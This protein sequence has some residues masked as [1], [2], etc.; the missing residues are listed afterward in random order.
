MASLPYDQRVQ[1]A[2][3]FCV[4]VNKMRDDAAELVCAEPWD[5]QT[6]IE[7]QGQFQ[8]ERYRAEEIAVLPISSEDSPR[9]V[10]C[11]GI[12]FI[13]LMKGTVLVSFR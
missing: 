1:A 2:R 11:R 8:L 5:L 13:D 4:T 3:K 10:I 7:K 12:R 6:L 9:W